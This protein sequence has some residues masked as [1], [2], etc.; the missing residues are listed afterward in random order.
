MSI[1]RSSK[2]YSTFQFTPIT[3]GNSCLPVETFWDV[4][5][6]NDLQAGWS[7]HGWLS[8]NGRTTDYRRLSSTKW[9]PNQRKFVFFESTNCLECVLIERQ[10]SAARHRVNVKNNGAS[11]F[12]DFTNDPWQ[13]SANGS[14]ISAKNLHASLGIKSWSVSKT[15][16]YLID[17]LW[18]PGTRWLVL[19]QE[20]YWSK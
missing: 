2:E 12:T 10:L 17:L 18:I 15:G 11:L 19:V 9:N 5:S 7:S 8:Q 1:P 20:R 14:K 16:N 13:K 4:S 6:I 3:T